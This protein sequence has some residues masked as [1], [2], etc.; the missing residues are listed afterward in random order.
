MGGG[1]G[2]CWRPLTSPSILAILAAAI[3]D[4]T[5]NQKIG[6]KRQ[7]WWYFVLDL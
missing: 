1:G 3:F 7:N 6:K 5:K 2:G 4:F